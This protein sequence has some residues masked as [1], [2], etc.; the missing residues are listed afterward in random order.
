MSFRTG[1]IAALETLLLGTV[2]ILAGGSGA[3]AAPADDLS[4]E[5]RVVGLDGKPVERSTVALWRLVPEAERLKK[6][7]GAGGR[8]FWHEAEASRTWEG[9]GSCATSDRWRCGHLAPGTYLATGHLGH[10]EPVP[11]GV[12]EPMVLDGT[13]MHNAL[14]LR[15]KPGPTVSFRLVDTANGRPLA[16]ARVTITREGSDLPPS[17]SWTLP[18][19]DDQGRAAIAQLPPGTYTIDAFKVAYAPEEL[20]YRAVEPKRKLVVSAGVDQVI[21]AAMAG[22]ALGQDE[23][24]RRWGWIATGRVVDEFG[25]PVADAEVRVATGRFTLRTGGQTRTGADGRFTVRF[26]QGWM[27]PNPASNE[28]AVFMIRKDGMIE[29]SRSR[30]G[31][32][33]IAR[34][35]PRAGVAPEIPRDRIILKGQPYPIDFV[36]GESA[37]LDVELSGPAD[38]SLEIAGANDRDRWTAAR[39]LRPNRWEVLPGRPWRFTLP[40]REDRPVV[41]SLPLTFPRAGRYHVVLRYTPD[42]E[43]GVYLLEISSV[44]GPVGRREIRDKIV[45][46]DPLALPPVPEALQERGRDILRRMADANRPWLGPPLEVG[47]YEYRFRLRDMA[48]QTIR[49]DGN[50]VSPSVRQGITYHS[51]V[52]AL[53][54]NPTA[55]TFRQVDVGDERITLAFTLKQPVGFEAGNGVRNG[56]FGNFSMPM[57]EGVLVLDARRLTPLECR[58][59]RV[60]ETFSQY[61]EVAKDRF[62]PLAIKIQYQYSHREMIFDWAF[63][64]VEPGLWLFAESQYQGHGTVARLD[65]VKV[66]GADATVIVRGG[67]HVDDAE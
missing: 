19:T 48:G 53:A 31:D 7:D 56:W 16:G 55:A 41:R 67:Q 30:P 49:V 52:H 65:Q 28:A 24:D 42:R 14:T 23:I 58:S 44:T 13:R 43:R 10:G 40:P 60:A 66:N 45:G 15:L 34:Q 12:S 35:M 46:D 3:L 33:L 18:V 17:W 1:R 32:H 26:G 64:V 2:C 20:E 6:D 8:Y 29:K 37:T 22:Q 57:R 4:L 11:F 36:M 5:V 63:Q 9:V 50:P 54:A 39:D 25:R 38:T 27:D 51:A 62:A 61:V 47:T 21:P 59:D